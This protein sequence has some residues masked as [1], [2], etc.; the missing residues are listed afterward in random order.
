MSR[1]AFLAVAL[2]LALLAGAAVRAEEPPPAIG[3]DAA[4]A[5]RTSQ[6][7]L[8]HPIGEY[9]LLD[10]EGRPLRLAGYRGKPLLVSFIY[11][12]CFQ[13]CPLTTRSLHDSVLALQSRFGTGRFNVV[14]IGFNQPADS[15]QAMKAFAAQQR[16][17][18]TP[19]WEFLSPHPA[20]VDALTADFGF[21]F[22]ATPAGFDHVLQVSVLDAEGRLVQQVYGDRPQTAQLAETL[23]RLFDGGPVSAPSALESL[24]ERVRIVCTVY[25]PKTGTYRVDNRLAIEIAGG[26]TFILAMALYAINEWRVHR[27]LRREAAAL[28]SRKSTPGAPAQTATG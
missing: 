23:Q 19:D 25:D 9:A 11:T 22:R 17:A 18:G 21:R 12:G 8:G 15:P 5:W 24:L 1:V 20:I 7:A 10:R 27:R 6:R 2:A 13:V 14:S 16:I 4:D 26:L 3:L 28:T